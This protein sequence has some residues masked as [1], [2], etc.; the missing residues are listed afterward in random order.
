MTT[1]AVIFDMDGVLSDSMHAHATAWQKIFYEIGIHIDLMD[2]YLLEGSNHSGI[3]KTI[4]DRNQRE[5]SEEMIGELS[6]QKLKMF[7]SLYAP[8]IFDK[9]KTILSALKSNGFRLAV[10]S[11]SNSSTVHGIIDR[12]FDAN[13][14]EVVVTG[15]DVANCKPAPDAYLLAFDKLQLAASECIVVENAPR[16]IIAAKRAGSFC[17]AITTTLGA[18]YLTCADI[19]VKD[20]HKLYWYLTERLCLK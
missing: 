12:C 10:V 3:I 18:Q 7:N 2:V 8:A 9:M 5:C 1:K 16:G 14:F 13:T 11:G 15:D 4:L 19:I 17:I 20:H 6:S